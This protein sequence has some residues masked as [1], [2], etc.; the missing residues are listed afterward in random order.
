[1]TFEW[2]KLSAEVRTA[3][4]GHA[5]QL[6]AAEHAMRSPKG[7]HILHHILQPH[8]APEKNQHYPKGDRIDAKTGAQYFYHCHRENHQTEEHGHFHCFIRYPQIPKNIQPKP[9]TD[10]DK[11]IHN[12]MTHLIAIGMNRHGKPIRLFTVNR[13]V[14]SEIVYEATHTPQLINQF[15]FQ[16]NTKT[17]SHWHILDQWVTSMLKL[18][19][20]Q[21]EYLQRRR[22]A[23]LKTHPETVYNDKTLNEITTL[24]IHIEAQI[25]WL[26]G[27]L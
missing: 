12:P 18:F 27:K 21:I 15:A 5:E 2:P 4:L 20:P 9:I 8:I 17:A 11:Y 1:M 13:W 14:T 24:S 19:A 22:D 6:L 3:L 26:L 10:W 25:Q 23:L 16:N 7:Q